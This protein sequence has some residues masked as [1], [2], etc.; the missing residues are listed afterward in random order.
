MIYI[1]KFSQYCILTK[2]DKQRLE[3]RKTKQFHF[4]IKVSGPHVQTFCIEKDSH[5]AAI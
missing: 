5:M 1:Y 4:L 2:H 3:E